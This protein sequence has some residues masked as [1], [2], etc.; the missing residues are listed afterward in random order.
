MNSD[1]TGSERINVVGTPVYLTVTQLNGIIKK[2]IEESPSL[3]K[4]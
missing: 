1:L 3:K 2:Q 4:V